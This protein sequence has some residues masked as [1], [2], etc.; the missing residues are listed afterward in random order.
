M[1]RWAFLLI[2]YAILTA[3]RVMVWCDNVSL[4][5]DAAVTAPRAP[6]VHYNLMEAYKAVGNEAGA[7]A[8]WRRLLETAMER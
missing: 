7:E 6:R 3:Q 2:L 8:E 4:W 5:E 1:K